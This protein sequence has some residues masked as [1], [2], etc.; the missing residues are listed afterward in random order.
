MFGPLKYIFYL[1]VLA[2]LGYVALYIL[3]SF[4]NVEQIDKVKSIELPKPQLV[5]QWWATNM[6]KVF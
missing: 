6:S 3:P 5:D 1:I 2:I 4:M